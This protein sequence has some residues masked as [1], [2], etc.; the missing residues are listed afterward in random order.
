VAGISKK[1]EFL[2]EEDLITINRYMILK[3][4]G[5]YEHLTKNILN[6]N[7]LRYVLESVQ[8]RIFGREIHVTIFEKA[9]AYAFNAIKNHIFY[10]GNKRTGIES[11]F[12]FLSNNGIKI[13]EKVTKEDIVNF[14][15]EIE[16]ENM[17]LND[18]AEWLKENSTRLRKLF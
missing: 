15:V 18:I 14:G 4:G 16:N 9:A 1:I 3:F 8:S 11:A 10:D 13:K 2:S 6:H 5:R 7:S 17:T 12:I